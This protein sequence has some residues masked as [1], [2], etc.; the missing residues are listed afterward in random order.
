MVSHSHRVSLPR[1]QKSEREKGLS[2]WRLCAIV[3]WGSRHRGYTCSCMRSLNDSSQTKVHHLHFAQTR[4][5]HKPCDITKTKN[6]IMIQ[7]NYQGSTSRRYSYL[8]L[9]FTVHPPSASLQSLFCNR[10]K[11]V[12]ISK[13]YR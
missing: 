12:L 8:D 13:V 3:C 5:H 2:M 10:R 6:L 11:R 1:V 4:N 9:G 7:G